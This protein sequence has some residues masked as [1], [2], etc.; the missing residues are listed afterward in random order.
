MVKK[1]VII[2]GGIAGIYVLR[3]LLARRDDVAGGLDLTLIKRE[4]S[5]WVSTCGLPFALRGWYGIKRTEIN[6]P[7]FFLDQGVDF[8]TETEVTKLS[9]ED[10]TITL[11]T[12]EELKY[13]YLVIA[14]GRSPSVPDAVAATELEGIYTFNNETDAERIEAAMEGAKNAFVRGR[15]II[16]L[17][18]AVAFATRGLKTTVLGG[19][20]S[21]LPSSLDPDMGDMVKKWLEEQHGIRFILERKEITAVKGEGGRVKSV[22]IG[23]GASAKELP[24][25]IV[26]IARGMKPN[27]KLAADAGIETGESGGI[28]TDSAMHVKK[29]SGRSYLKDVFSLGDCTEVIDAITH[30]PRLS[31]LASTVV[32]QA[33]VVADNILSDISAQPSLYSIC[34]PCLS[35]TVAEIGGLL[36]GSVGVTSE[37][38]A[39]V[40]I[41]TLSGEATKLV[42]ARY[43]PG[44][45]PLTM[46]LL[47]EAYTHKLIG[48]QMVGESTV[49]ER[50]NELELAIRA[51]MTAEEMRN[52]ERCY[53]P[54]LSLLID[55]T[56]DA[57]EKAIGISPVY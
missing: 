45:K 16:G 47:F 38:A 19:P 8:R 56:I 42:K 37:M 20:P 6:E 25:D 1:V 4:R 5:G 10:K 24:A 53:D 54:S 32:V 49:A 48:A 57:T 30:R 55:V 51:G 13:D 11:V 14:T 46:K 17:Q 52:T 50:V 43:F 18:A 3:N 34:E 9:P 31:Q 35:P 21:L 27:T 28:V 22:V 26:V 2:G 15:G 44:A 12:G 23:E 7:K 33:K 29:K 40:G 36:V 41:K 39:R